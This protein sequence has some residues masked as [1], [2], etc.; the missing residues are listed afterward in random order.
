MQTVPQVRARQEQLE[1]DVRKDLTIIW[2]AWCCG[3]VETSATQRRKFS[4]EAS[5][6]GFF[7]QHDNIGDSGQPNVVEDDVYLRIFC[8]LVCCKVDFFSAP[9]QVHLY[10]MLRSTG[11]CCRLVGKPNWKSR[12]ELPQIGAGEQGTA[13]RAV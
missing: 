9:G 11:V 3:P 8:P 10:C 6:R 7:C 5:A 12:L 13:G 2:A 1:V 4:G